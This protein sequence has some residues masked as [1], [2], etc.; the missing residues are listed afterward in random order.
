VS[1]LQLARMPGSS[2]AAG[3]AAA[4]VTDFLNAAYYAHP[5]SE[6]DPADLRLAYGI[7]GT[8]WHREARRLGARDLPAF[9][10]A[11]TALRL[12]ADGGRGRLR[13][14]A[15]LEGAA[16]LLGPW[17]PAAW[18][19]P[20]RRAHGI[21]FETVAERERFHPAARLHGAALAE[22]TPPQAPSARR[23]RST[24][25]AVELPDLDRA[26]GL[27]QDPARWPD[28]GAG[29]GRFTAV[30]PGGLAGQTF[31]IEVA[32][33]A[34]PRAPV[35][36]RGYVTC[37]AL[38][39][40]GDKVLG[41]SVAALARLVGGEVL[42]EGATPVAHVELTTHDGHFLG[43]ALSHLVVFRTADGRG[44]IRDVGEW[45]P[46][47]LP[48][49]AAYAG[50]GADAQHAFWGPED[51]TGSMLVQLAEVSAGQAGRRGP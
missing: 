33:E 50:G 6:R 29:G 7:L 16:E 31:E 13:R 21:A 34:V 38:W 27:L 24:Y 12:S 51:R 22:L 49:A 42:P 30:R 5:R 39:L 40:E 18:D 43:R 32:L 45:D 28:I 44:Y 9:A 2:I 36:T 26:L 25:P 20:A 37:T 46:L 4:W 8:R 47:P 17:F 3:S 41:P 10:L 48:L 15:L 19:D 35:F 14:P 23:Q 1:T 11:W